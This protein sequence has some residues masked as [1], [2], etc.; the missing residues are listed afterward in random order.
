VYGIDHEKVLLAAS[1][2][3]NLNEKRKDLPYP[4]KSGRGIALSQKYTAEPGASAAV[5]YRTDGTVDV[6]VTI[7]EL[8]QGTR[9]GIS[10]IVAE[11]LKIPIGKIRIVQPDTHLT[12]YNS[13][14]E[15]SRQMYNLGNATILACK[16]LKARILDLASAKTGIQNRDLQFGEESVFSTDGQRIPISNLFTKMDTDGMH[17]DIGNDFWGFGT[18]VVP[19]GDLDLET[20]QATMPRVNTSCANAAWG[21][22]L[23]VNVETGEVKVDRTVIVADAGTLINPKLAEGQIE[24]A[25]SQGLSTA[26]YEELVFEKGKILNP[27]FK[28]YKMLN[29]YNASKMEVK[30]L[31][32]PSLDGPYGAKPLGELGIVGISP[33]IAN[34][35]EDAVGVRIK[36]LPITA[37]RVLQAMKSEGLKK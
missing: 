13:G 24:G 6:F 2:M 22:E 32:S 14:A 19:T 29:S 37:E 25:I 18:W 28:D 16:D 33:A 34:A 35:V 9:T 17:L 1:E 30:F 23:A 5:R 15:S 27:D 21:V 11:E 4:W 12:A 7:Q 10:Q 20:S 26:L 36:D 3:M 8:G 31:G